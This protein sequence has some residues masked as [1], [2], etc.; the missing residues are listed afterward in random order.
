ML[1]W[2]SI[3]SSRSQEVNVRGWEVRE[4]LAS[5]KGEK[6]GEGSINERECARHSVAKGYRPYLRADHRVFCRSSRATIYISVPGTKSR[7]SFH[8]YFHR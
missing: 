2:K 5:L 3:L 4:G 6:G 8:L 7:G 1:K